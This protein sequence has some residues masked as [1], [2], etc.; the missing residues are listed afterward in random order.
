MNQT[1]QRNK[2]LE[3]YILLA[4]D[5]VT[6]ITSYLLAML[7]RFGSVNGGYMNELHFSTCLCFM[8]ISV[9]YSL[10]LDWNDGFLR[11]GYLVEFVAILKYNIVMVVSVA[12]FLFM[13]G[14]AEPFSRMVWGYV[15][16][17]N[18]ILTFAG[19]I[20]VKKFL[21]E[22]Y[23]S[24]HSR[25]KVMVVT[26]SQEVDRLL[27]NLEEGLPVNCDITSVAL[28]G[29]APQREFFFR[30]S[31]VMQ[32]EAAD[33]EGLVEQAKQ[34][35]LDEVFIRMTG[36]PTEQV[37]KLIQEFE[38]MG[39]ICHYSIEIAEWNS[40]ES[41]IQKFANYTVVSYSVYRIDYRRRMIKR[42][43]DIIGGFIGLLMTMLLYP[44]IALAIKCNSKGPVLFS[45][46]RVGKNGRRFKI[47][48]FRSMYLDAEERKKQLMD[49]NEMSGYMFKMDNDPRITP[50]GRF[51]RK[52]SLDE[53]PQ[54]FNVL[55]GDMSLIGTRP[56][57]E[58][59]FEKYSPYY[60]R[61]LCMTPG[62][63][64]LWQ[65]SGRSNITD[66]EEVVKLDLEYIDNWSITLDI[67]I[68][69]KT[70]WVVLTGSGSK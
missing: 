32:Y 70:V 41:S 43:V 46:I 52:T 27:A 35:P 61:R 42:V 45:Q 2:V 22:Y 36:L 49:Q 50:V 38:S 59:E 67:K 11:R 19:H 26:D 60:R 23:R 7:A 25:I 17:F 30:S 3:M 54:F 29:Q 39:I 53:F 8:F 13:T 57:T 16:I 58:E 66:F 44:F 20:V 63:T 47:Y 14:Q 64:G 15:F 34:L 31:K 56:P 48:K 5:L 6:I 62:L 24:E 37:Q 69:L 28:W 10:M 51:L 21:K 1:N 55:R 4:V 65:V 40:K 33:V 12:T 9:M 68:L 18:M